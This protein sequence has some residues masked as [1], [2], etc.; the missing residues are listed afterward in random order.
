MLLVRA[1]EIVQLME[2]ELPF[3]TKS[4]MELIFWNKGKRLSHG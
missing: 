4:L 3:E 2:G 1:N